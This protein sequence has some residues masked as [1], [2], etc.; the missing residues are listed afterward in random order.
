MNTLKFHGTD[1]GIKKFL[2]NDEDASSMAQM[3]STRKT[4]KGDKWKDGLK[5]SCDTLG[6]DL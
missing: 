2:G 1:L 4:R 3:A 6:Q 5:K